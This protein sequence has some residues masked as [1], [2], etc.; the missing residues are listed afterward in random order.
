MA[1][2]I[3]PYY[4]EAGITI[5]HG[6]CR[7]VLPTLPRGFVVV[8]DQPYGTGWIRGGGKKAGEFK[9]KHER[10]SWDVWNLDWVDLCKDARRIAA[11]SPVGKE[12]ELAGKFGESSRLIYRKTNVRPGGA[13]YEPVRVYPPL[14]SDY[15]MSAYN[16]D[17]PFH[18]C[19]KPIELMRWILGKVCKP[20]DLVVDVFMGSGTTLRAAKDLGLQ[21]IGIE[22]EE[23]Y[24]E[25]AANRLRQE[26]LSFVA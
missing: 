20:N 23:K 19:Q 24:C 16:G 15:E 14:P 11:F 6:D 5:Y 18:P 17:A 2:C 12:L 13:D 4:Q 26:V 8:T 7:D 1:D 10:P 21:A 22:L 9:A 25:I 3:K